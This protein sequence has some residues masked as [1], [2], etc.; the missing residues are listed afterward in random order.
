MSTFFEQH[1]ILGV[2]FPVEQIKTIIKE[3]EYKDEPYYDSST[4]RLLRIS[5]VQTKPPQVEY[6]FLDCRGEYLYEV[7]EAACQKQ[8]KLHYAVVEDESEIIFGFDVADSTDD[9]SYRSTR[10]L[11]GNMTIEGLQYLRDM[12]TENIL[13]FTE[14]YDFATYGDVEL[15]LVWTAM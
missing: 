12:L 10:L 4:G 13:V 5:K 15:H 3:A 14:E 11:T 6:K 7:L 2:R 1:A 9:I 8:E